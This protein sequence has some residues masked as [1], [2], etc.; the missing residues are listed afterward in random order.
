MKLFETSYTFLYPWSKVSAAHWNKY[1]ND[2]CP[3]VVTIDV[4]DRSV[5]PKTGILRTERLVKI[6]QNIPRIFRRIFGDFAESYAREVSEVDPKNKLL[7]MTSTNLTMRNIIN[8]SEIITY[9]ED[10]NDPSRTLFKQEARIRCNESINK[11]TN[12]I[13]D[14]FIQRFR[15]NSMKGRQGFEG[16]LEK[17]MV[18]NET[19][20]L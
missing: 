9:A 15:E 11:F 5:D 14:F 20:T 8:V 19:S 10:P 1:P 17:L 7:K 18:Q 4:L 3:H 16:V 12:Y 2:N 6:H 13:E